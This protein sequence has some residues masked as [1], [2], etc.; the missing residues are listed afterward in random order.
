MKKNVFVIIV[1]CCVSLIAKADVAKYCMSYADYVAGNWKSVS[2][3]TEGRTKQV[4]QLKSDDHCVYFKTGDKESDQIL[5]KQAF[6]VKY[7]YQLYV[8]SRNLRYNDIP[9]ETSKYI[10]AVPYGDD[11]L[12]IMA[13]KTNGLLALADVGCLA[14]SIFVSNNWVSLGLLG[15]SIG[16]IGHHIEP[17]ATASSQVVNGIVLSGDTR[18]D[19]AVGV[20]SLT[21]RELGSA[22]ADFNVVEVP[23]LAATRAGDSHF[24]PCSGGHTTQGDRVVGC[25]TCE[26]HRLAGI[27][28]RNRQS[29]GIGAVGLSVNLHGDGTACGTQVKGGSRYR[30]A[31]A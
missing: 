18:D 22:S 3:L 30:A 6:A 28:A 15:G 26:R 2:E 9:L 17:V 8:N 7:G 31:V 24:L 10:Q 14:S 29:R 27:A 21:G 23:T 4:C 19:T 11:K 13:S 16:E 25:R 12:C 20:T 5:K 1:L